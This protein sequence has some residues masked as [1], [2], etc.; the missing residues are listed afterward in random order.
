MTRLATVLVV[1][2]FVL[3]FMG[4]QVTTTD[5]GDSVPTWPASFFVPKDMAQVWELGHRWFAGT[6][7]LVAVALAGWVLAKVRAPTPRKLAIAASILGVLQALGGCLGVLSKEKPVKAV[8][9]TLL[10]QAFLAL[11]AALA[12]ALRSTADR[13]VG[14]APSASF[15]RWPFRRAFALAI[16]TWVQAGLGA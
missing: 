4:G 2:T 3:I 10:A 5:S 6:V 15:P 1:L 13:Q 7:G 11:V 16:V 12:C 14:A 9:H 8:V